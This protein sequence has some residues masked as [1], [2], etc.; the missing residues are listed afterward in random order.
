[1]ATGPQE[2]GQVLPIDG[3]RISA[4]S[5]GVRYQNRLDMVV[6]ELAPGTRSSGVF[7]RNAFCAAPVVIAREHL[8]SPT[9]HREAETAKAHRG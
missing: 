8:K 3:I 4:V 6:F 7:T 9:A 2:L 5:A 1:M